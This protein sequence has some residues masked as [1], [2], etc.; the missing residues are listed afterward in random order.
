MKISKLDFP[1][2]TLDKRLLLS[3]GT[4]LTPE[5]LDTLISTHNG[6]PYE[7]LP[8]LEYG[9]V[10]KD[11][12]HLIRKPPYN[13]IFGK[14]ENWTALRT[15]EKIRLIEPVLESLD[16][17]KKSDFY[18]YRHILLVFALA[19]MLSQDLLENSQDWIIEAMAGQMHDFGKINVPLQVLKKR[20]P[21]TRTERNILEHHALAGFVLLSYYLQDSQSISARIAKEHHERRDGSGYPDGILL[22]DRMVEI[23]SAC[24]VYDAL[25]SPRPYRLTPFDN[26]TALEEITRM[27]QEGQ[28]SWDVVKILV[29]YNRKDKPNIADCKVSEEKRGTPPAHNLYGIIINDDPSNSGNQDT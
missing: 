3:A 1:V 13:R 23:I 26:R 16:Y 18:T 27:A 2:Y 15:M 8:F 24:D 5:T 4:L 7:S 11:I 6:T 17:F 14:Q 9:T 25:L 10:Y 29:S 12:L 21:L 19:T 28:L 20:N 22:K